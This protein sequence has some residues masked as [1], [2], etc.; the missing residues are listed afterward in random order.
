M[1]AV[2]IVWLFIHENMRNVARQDFFISS[3]QMEH[4]MEVFTVQGRDKFDTLA[5]RCSG[6]MRLV[7]KEITRVCLTAQSLRDI[8]SFPPLLC[9]NRQIK[10]MI[11]H[12]LC[13]ILK[14]K[15]LFPQVCFL[16]LDQLMD[17]HSLG[18]Y[19]SCSYINMLIVSNPHIEKYSTQAS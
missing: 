14:S 13:A 18:V 15:A 16:L 3:L 7:S 12:T 4:L 19:Y 6:C 8:D 5:A 2:E 1:P 17:G 10:I 9:H 11:L